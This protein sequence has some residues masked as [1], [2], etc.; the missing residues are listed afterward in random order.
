MDT[1]Q[2]DPIVL[3]NAPEKLIFFKF[4]SFGR[5]TSSCEQIYDFHLCYNDSTALAIAY[6]KESCTRLG[7]FQWLQIDPDIIYLQFA[8][9]TVYPLCFSKWI[10]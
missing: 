2:Q 5:N 7:T 3:Q 1:T 4:W 10:V 8:F 9:L 6:D